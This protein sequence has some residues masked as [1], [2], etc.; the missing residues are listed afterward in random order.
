MLGRDGA[1]RVRGAGSEGTIGPLPTT[2]ASSCWSTS[3]TGTTASAAGLPSGA[4]TFDVRRRVGAFAGSGSDSAVS[5]APPPD[6]SGAT[7]TSDRSAARFAGARRRGGASGG[8]TNTSASTEEADEARVSEDTSSTG[9]DIGATSS[10]A[11]TSALTAAFRLP[12]NRVRFLGA[13]LFSFVFTIAGALLGRLGDRA[14]H[15]SFSRAFF[16]CA[17]TLLIRHVLQAMSCSWSGDR[18]TPLPMLCTRT[19]QNVSH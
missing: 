4:E 12:N 6:A 14:T 3:A 7:G 9:A 8:S 1:R 18:V 16:A 15:R 10:G 2:S 17:R 11:V 19:I 13:S 5:G